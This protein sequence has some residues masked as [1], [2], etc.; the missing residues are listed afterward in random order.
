M[1]LVLAMLLVI[2]AI[3]CSRASV[4]P[5]HE[6]DRDSDGRI[7]QEEATHDVVLS[8]V[9]A[10]VDSDENGELTAF[11]YLQANRL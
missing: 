3:A 7:S 1:K 4:A 10:D 11:E 9:F 5:F 6:L 2:S 8:E